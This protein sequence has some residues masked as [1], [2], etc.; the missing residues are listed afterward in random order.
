MDLARAHPGPDRALS[1]VTCH[2]EMT[3]AKSGLRPGPSC[4]SSVS[5]A[6][7][8]PVTVKC[9]G[10]K[11]S[12]KLGRTKSVE[13]ATADPR[14]RA[15]TTGAF[16]PGIASGSELKFKRSNRCRGKWVRRA[17]DSACASGCTL[18]WRGSG[19]RGGGSKLSARRV[20]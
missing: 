20:V 16:T 19:Q 10:K 18:V 1:H 12:N 2:S 17:G 13:H 3:A 9:V 14:N 4:L 5:L 11:M 7:A 15:C 8:Q 6:V